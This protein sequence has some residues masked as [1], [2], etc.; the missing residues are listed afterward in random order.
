MII[1]IEVSSSIEQKKKKVLQLCQEKK[2]D[3][4]RWRY[5]QS[6]LYT[7]AN[8][9]TQI[10]SVSRQWKRKIPTKKNLFF[11]TWWRRGKAK[12]SCRL[13]DFQE[14]SISLISDVLEKHS[15]RLERVIV[16]FRRAL[17]LGLSSVRFERSSFNIENFSV[18]FENDRN[19]RHWS[20][21]CSSN[22]VR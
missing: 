20:W 17:L 7:E 14:K 11:N 1:I 4:K 13:D 16:L 21:N 2:G 3:K 12:A 6:L 18:C 19:R 10:R 5:W 8:A 22:I 9:K 15:D